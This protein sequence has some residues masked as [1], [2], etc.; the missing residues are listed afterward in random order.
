MC[1]AKIEPNIFITNLKCFFYFQA[2]LSICVNDTYKIILHMPYIML[3]LSYRFH[4]GMKKKQ[5][6]LKPLAQHSIYTY[7][8]TISTVQ[9]GSI[10]LFDSANSQRLI[11]TSHLLSAPNSLLRVLVYPRYRCWVDGGRDRTLNLSNCQAELP[12][13]KFLVKT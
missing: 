9:R 10:S 7:N 5:Q 8:Y 1:L 11:E 4:M 13:T 3:Y 2:I 6:S 12:T